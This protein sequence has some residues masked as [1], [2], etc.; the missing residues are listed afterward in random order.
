MC[1]PSE[2]EGAAPAAAARC[3]QPF[4]LPLGDSGPPAA[5]RRAP[6]G[7]AEWDHGDPQEPLISSPIQQWVLG[8][9]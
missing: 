5:P 4:L 9:P 7:R 3:L 1:S 6:A 2:N 8:Y